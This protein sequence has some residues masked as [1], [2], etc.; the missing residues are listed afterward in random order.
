MVAVIYKRIHLS[1]S[2]KVPQVPTVDVPHVSPGYEVSSTAYG[3][4]CWDLG[5]DDDQASLSTGNNI[6]SLVSCRVPRTGTNDICW[7]KPKQVPKLKPN[8][9][10]TE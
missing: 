10:R 4:I 3:A 1:E 6:V 9:M 2:K 8:G 5:F 7:S